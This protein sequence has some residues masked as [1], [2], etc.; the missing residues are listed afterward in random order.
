[1][2]TNEISTLELTRDEINNIRVALLAYA[3]ISNKDN[4]EATA[5]VYYALDCKIENQ[6]K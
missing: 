5:Q 2:T 4:R 1:M 6:T 3:R